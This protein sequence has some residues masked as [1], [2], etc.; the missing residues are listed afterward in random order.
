WHDTTITRESIGEEEIGEST[1][2]A[3]ENDDY[4]DVGDYQGT[5]G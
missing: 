4:S 5:Y 2:E 3:E 1:N